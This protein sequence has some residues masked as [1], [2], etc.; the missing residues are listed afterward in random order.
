MIQETFARCRDQGRIALI[1]YLPVGYPT[2]ADTPELVAALVEGGC[3]LVELGVP[4]SDPLADGATIQRASQRALANGVNL[5]GALETAARLRQRV[6]VPLLLMGYCN[7]FYHYGWHRLAA[8]AA[9]AGVQGL[10]V[11]DLPPEEADELLAALAPHGVDNIAMAAPTSGPA[12]LVTICRRASGFVYCVALTGVTG[13]R[14][15]LAPDLGEFLARVRR[16]TE[17]PLA[18]GFGLSRPAQVAAVAQLAD[19]AVVGSAIVDLIDSLPPAE[20]ATGLRRY[21]AELRG[22]TLRPVVV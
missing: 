8:A 9:A 1:A 18:V 4:F 10:I 22:A 12:R 20:R 5:S 6:D 21:A 2:L 16:Q 15:G 7:P 11:P 13:A 17:L 3:D 19:G 14:Q